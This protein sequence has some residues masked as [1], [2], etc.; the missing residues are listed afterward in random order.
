MRQIT[1]GQGLPSRGTCPMDYDRSDE[2]LFNCLKCF[3]VSRKD[4]IFQSAHE[5]F[6]HFRPTVVFLDEGSRG[7]AELL[8]PVWIR[9]REITDSAKS[10]GVSATR[11]FSPDRTGRPSAPTDVET[12]ALLIAMASKILRRVPPPIRRGT[13]QIEP[14]ATNGRTSSTHPVSRTLVFFSG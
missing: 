2:G 9:S 11:M 5:P 8:A 6:S 4:S 13:M 12:T 7:R 14:R 3:E 10:F 1:G